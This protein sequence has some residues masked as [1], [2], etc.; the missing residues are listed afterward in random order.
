MNQADDS[1][2][3]ILTRARRGRLSSA[4]QLQLRELLDKSPEARLLYRAGRAFDREGL[5]LSDDDRRFERMVQRV[6]QHQ[7]K[8][9][10]SVPL[11]WR[12]AIAVA[13]GVLLGAAAVG[14]IELSKSWVESRRAKSPPSAEPGASNTH[15]APPSRA[16][17]PRLGELPAAK[18]AAEPA[19]SVPANPVPAV[20]AFSDAPE[21][22]RAAPKVAPTQPVLPVVVAAEPPTSEVPPDPVPPLIDADTSLASRDDIATNARSDLAPVPALE[23]RQT[24]A[25]L[26]LL[27]NR[28]RV[29]GD[30]QTAIAMYSKLQ[31]QHPQSQEAQT[32]RLSLGMLYLQRHQAGAALVQFRTYRSAGSGPGLAEALY[33][34]AEALGQLGRVSEQQ[35]ALREIVTR[36]PGS[37][38]ATQAQKRLVEPN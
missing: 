38:Y 7:S 5:A 13:A 28:A 18:P 8:A 21:S 6:R 10:R 27:A 31:T 15:S 9:R 30:V 2:E 25:E 14:A 22:G 29:G 26:F 11:R 23:A 17:A 24:P 32:A 34:E 35:A 20:A 12:T 37:A 4:E 36:F 33:G 3:D 19:V 16:Y 1:P